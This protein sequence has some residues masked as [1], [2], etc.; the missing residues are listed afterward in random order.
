MVGSRK[1]LAAALSLALCY[2]VIAQSQ[3]EGAQKKMAETASAKTLTPDDLDRI[4]AE[5]DADPAAFFAEPVELRWWLHGG[6][7]GSGSDTV[8]IAVAEPGGT[9]T[10]TYVR[11]RPNDEPGP[12]MKIKRFDGEIEPEQAAVVARAV[13]R[14][15]LF[16]ETAPASEGPRLAD[17]RKETWDFQRGGASVSKTVTE[18]FPDD[19]EHPRASFHAVRDFVVL[20]AE[21]P[22]ESEKATG[23][24]GAP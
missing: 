19:L 20:N 11:A 1:W 17:G 5:L 22:V 10:A 12:P 8:T 16:R 7:P 14:S 6:E 4:A 2:C 18:P 3:P 15:P 9:L 13:L 23:K 24:D 21:R